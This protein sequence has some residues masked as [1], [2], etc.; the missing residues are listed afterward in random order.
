ME[1]NKRGRSISTD[2][3]GRKYVRPKKYRKKPA[4]P[5]T[6]EE[7]K[8][9]RES[10][11]I[12]DPFDELLNSSD[13]EKE[14]DWS[15]GLSS[16]SESDGDPEDQQC[17]DSSIN[18]TEEKIYPGHH[19]DLKTS[20]LVIWLY[21]LSF[22]VTDIQFESLLC[23][24]NLHFLVAHPALSSVYKFKRYLA[25]MKSVYTKHYFCNTCLTL[26][27]ESAQLCPN[28][29]CPHQDLSKQNAKGYFLELSIAS[30][31]EA[32]LSR[33][34]IQKALEKQ[35]KRGRSKGISDIADGALYQ[36]LCKDGGPL[37]DKYPYNISFSLNTDGVNLVNSRAI[38]VWPVYLWI[39]ELPYGIRK[40]KQNMIVA[41]VWFSSHKPLMDMFLAPIGR[42]LKQLEEIGVDVLVEGSVVTCRCFLICATADIP[43]KARMLNMKQHN[44][45]HACGKCFQP[46][47]NLRTT[48][49]GNVRVFPFGKSYPKRT[50][51][52]FIEDARQAVNSGKPVRGIKGPCILSN[53][54]YFDLA[55]SVTIDY[56]H[57]ILQGVSKLV[58]SLWF[59]ATHS[60]ELFS[61]H[62]HVALVEKRLSHVKP[63]RSVSRMPRT[64]TDSG[65]W[66]ASE[67][68]AWLFYFSVPALHDLMDKHF[69][70]HWCAFLEAIYLLSQDCVMPHDLQQA[71]R[72]LHY[73][74]FMFSE[75]Y[76]ERYMTLNVHYLLHL[77]E[78][79]C[80]LGPLWAHSCFGFE[81]ING[82]LKHMFNGTRFIDTQIANT[83][84]MLQDIPRL[85]D[86]VSECAGVSKL[87]QKFKKR[88]HRQTSLSVLMLKNVRFLGKN[89]L[90]ELTTFSCVLPSSNMYFY[91]RISYS[92]QV[93]HS[94]S[95]ARSKLCNSF[96][97][98]YINKQSE[99]R[100]GYVCWFA[101]DPVGHHKVCLIKCLNKTNAVDLCQVSGAAKKNPQNIKLPSIHVLK[102]TG[103]HDLINI[104]GIAALCVCVAIQDVTFVMEQP[105]MTE[106]S[107]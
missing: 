46:G 62:K 107:L 103:G 34:D 101:N 17:D 30:Q 79:V 43:A 5:V 59:S 38:S 70:Y 19:L 24:V 53:L 68:R 98:K 44:G 90:P 99:I 93:I 91:R 97:V 14:Y 2:R 9:A 75:L 22:G 1:A 36:K 6:T 28:K 73:F 26:V 25:G 20:M 72:L 83:V 56:M 63:P 57:C 47:T 31:V 100:F 71:D 32:I 21:V 66:K 49:G 69:L 106:F 13:S 7:S 23:L 15:S 58:C 80:T 76:G 18:M 52:D 33:P 29:L 41:G 86:Q 84:F 89:F 88:S 105:N 3:M 42:A 77:S 55:T 50:H 81:S 67:H 40:Q 48:T 78:I 61:L 37:S 4:D 60:S 39:N 51:D 54:K 45:D 12:L 85:V 87:I 11:D 8:D 96:T 64:V 74:V 102:E 94:M 65:Q 92:G 35:K 82:E 104:S 27:A 10:E 95:Y 16:D